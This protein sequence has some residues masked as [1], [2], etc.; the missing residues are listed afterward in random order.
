[1]SGQVENTTYHPKL[2]VGMTKESI[3]ADIDAALFKS[4]QEREKAYNKQIRLFDYTNKLVPGEVDDFISEKEIEAYN[5]KEK[6]N[7]TWKTIGLVALGIGAVVVGGVVGKKLA[8]NAVKQQK[9][10]LQIIEEFKPAETLEEAKLRAIKDYG[11]KDF[12]IKDLNCANDALCSLELIK[13]RNLGPLRLKKIIEVPSLESG[14]RSAGGCMSAKNGVMKISREEYIA[15]LYNKQ[16]LLWEKIPVDKMDEF[17]KLA[18]NIH[19]EIELVKVAAKF[20]IKAENL[21]ELPF[22]TFIHEYGHRAHFLSVGKKKYYLMGKLDELWRLDIKDESIHNEFMSREVQKIID[23][24]PFLGKYAKESPAEFV[25]EVYSALIHNIK[26]PDD[27]M[28]LYR[29]YHGPTVL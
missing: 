2:Y 26:L 11:L 13:N 20:G 8:A 22:Q 14:I 23:N 15:N 10:V 25:A 4:E 16:T 17:K 19:S 18:D 24:C 29:K 9:N 5:Q 6:I 1:M 3:S 27:V 21:H 7:K 28:A 12:D